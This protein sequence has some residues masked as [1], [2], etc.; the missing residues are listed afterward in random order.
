MLI[1]IL[2]ALLGTR[3]GY[4]VCVLLLIMILLAIVY[5]RIYNRGR[6]SVKA[7]QT[8]R[9]INNVLDKLRA[10]E[11]VFKLD[12]H[13]RRIRLRKWATGLPE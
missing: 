8:E 6:T 1:N 7:E 3:F 10:D 5:W 4:Y 2:S 13:S 11:E 12:T 9:A